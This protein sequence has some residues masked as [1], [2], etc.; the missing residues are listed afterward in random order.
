MNVPIS[1]SFFKPAS[2]ENIRLNITITDYNGQIW[3]DHIIFEL[4]PGK[5]I[6]IYSKS[7]DGAM[8]LNT[9]NPK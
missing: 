2:N 3:K 5:I 7:G 6:P 8:D 1:I 9:L 4:N